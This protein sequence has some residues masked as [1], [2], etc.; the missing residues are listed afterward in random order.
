MMTVA[1]VF[2][3]G[4]DWLLGVQPESG[5]NTA[6]VFQWERL[7]QRDRVWPT[8]ID[9]STKTMNDRNA[10]LKAFLYFIDSL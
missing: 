8:A 7:S 3:F 5:H 1:W 4:C 2:I 10:E 9:M 6:A